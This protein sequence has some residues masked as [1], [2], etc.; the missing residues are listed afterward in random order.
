MS[1]L[2]WLQD[3]DPSRDVAQASERGDTRLLAFAGRA[4]TLPGVP[5][6]SMAQAKTS[7]GTR[8]LP[9]STDAVQGDVHLKL[10][11]QAQDYAAAYN[12]LMLDSCL[13]Q[14]D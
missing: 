12:Q 8:I 11:Q 5:A 13:K 3:A 9:G 14:P 2:S 10:L 7:C 1:A 6:E 4:P